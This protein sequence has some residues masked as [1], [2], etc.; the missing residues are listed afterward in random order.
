[1][2]RVFVSL[3]FSFLVAM[4]ALADPCALALDRE[5]FFDNLGLN[6]GFL[7]RITAKIETKLKSPHTLSDPEALA[8]NFVVA[9]DSLEKDPNNGE[10]EEDLVT[11]LAEL[12]FSIHSLNSAYD[13]AGIKF[14][15]QFKRIFILAPEKAWAL[16]AILA[17]FG[18][19]SLFLPDLWHL[20]STDGVIKFSGKDLKLLAFLLLIPIMAYGRIAQTF[21]DL[22]NRVYSYTGAP[23]ENALSHLFGSLRAKRF[24][25]RFF[26]QLQVRKFPAFKPA[27]W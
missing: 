7:Q 26:A 14:R 3:I 21:P 2:G 8:D 9:F 12:Y 1:M 11:V 22:S 4:K 6:Y 13:F 25:R 17:S 18:A 27:E 10:K 5:S 23:V 19:I 16:F 24:I 15:T 20:Y